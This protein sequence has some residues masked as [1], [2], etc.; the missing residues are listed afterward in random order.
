MILVF[1]I[2]DH[3]DTFINLS[4]DNKTVEKVVL[5]PVTDPGDDAS[6][7]YR[8]AIWDKIAE[9]VGNLPAL[10]EITIM[11]SRFVDGEWE[12]IVPDWD[13]FAC[14][15]RTSSAGYPSMHARRESTT[16]GYRNSASFCWSGSWTGH[17]NRI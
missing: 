1:M 15:L 9:G 2:L 4:R 11:D 6:G 14:I 5:V 12:A 7:T 16:M 17:D 13:I 10:R 3:V 8:H